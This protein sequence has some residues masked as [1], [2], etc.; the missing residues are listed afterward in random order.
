MPNVVSFKKKLKEYKDEE[1]KSNDFSTGL[2]I[3][4]AEAERESFGAKKHKNDEVKAWIDEIEKRLAIMSGKLP[5]EELC[6]CRRLAWEKFMENVKIP[7]PMAEFFALMKQA[8]GGE[9]G[10]LRGRHFLPWA[11][12]YMVIMY[13][14]AVAHW[15]DEFTDSDLERLEN[16]RAGR[17]TPRELVLAQ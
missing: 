17:D 2:S 7:L 15:P 5:Y 10:V 13:G 11:T 12:A 1:L 8:H 4:V 14:E 6:A 9:L 16:W 3:K